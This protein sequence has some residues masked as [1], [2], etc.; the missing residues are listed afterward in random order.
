MMKQRNKTLAF[1][2]MERFFG[3]MTRDMAE[4]LPDLNGNTEA[5]KVRERAAWARH[6]LKT[7]DNRAK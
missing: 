6:L 2:N 1:K 5:G 4:T 7:L 3:T